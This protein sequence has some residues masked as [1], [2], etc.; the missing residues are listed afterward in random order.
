MQKRVLVTG[1]TGFLGSHILLKLLQQ[2]YMVRTTV[3]SLSGKDKVLDML[4]AHGIKETGTIDFVVAD[5]SKDDGWDDAMDSCDFVLSVASP[6]FFEKPKNE[7]DA[8]RPAV[9][10]IIRVLKAAKKA[11]VVRV[12]MTSNYGAVGFSSKDKKKQVTE[13]DW[14][15]V[16]EKGLSIYEKSKLV[17]EKEAWAYMKGE[18]KGM[19]FVTV[20]P[21]AIFGPSLSEHLSGSFELLNGIVDGT[22]S[23]VPNIPLNIVDVRDVADMHVKAMNVKEAA[24]KRFIASSKGQITLPEIANLIKQKRPLM[25]EKITGKT[26]PDWVIKVGALANAHIREGALLL[27]L[28]RNVSTEQAKKILNWKPVYG[29]EEIILSAVD[30][31][32]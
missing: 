16:H 8:M 32:K 30:C 20:N 3:R 23:R 13:K 14:T 9:E 29:Q 1:G 12:V 15:D 31:M 7:E 4:K 25:A 24:G 11:G 17:A 2:G 18:G 28:N 26:L 6:V 5:L 22:M 21:V 19:E 27:S 10:G